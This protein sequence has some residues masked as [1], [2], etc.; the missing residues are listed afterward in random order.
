[1]SPCP[2]RL[3]F[4]GHDA[5]CPSTDCKIS[6]AF[7]RSPGLKVLSGFFWVGSALSVIL[8]AKAGSDGRMFG[9]AGSEVLDPPRWEVA[10][11]STYLLGVLNN[12]DSYEIGAEFLTGRVR[13]G[14]F[15]RDDWLRGYNQ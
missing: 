5:A 2:L 3:E 6:C 1:M 9:P 13:W 10:A 7:Y 4:A 14:V 12:P 11:E 15:D 8:S